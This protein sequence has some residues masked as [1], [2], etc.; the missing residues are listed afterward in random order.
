[1]AYI[2]LQFA[3][4]IVYVAGTINGIETV[5]EDRQ[6]KWYGYV[7]AVEDALYHLSL[8]IYDEAGNQTAY[9]DTLYYEL[10]WFV[11]DRTA[12][13]VEDRTSKGVL[14]ARDLNRIEKNTFTIGDLT[15]IAIS[16][17]YDWKN[18][19][20]PK[21]GDYERIRQ[22]TQKIRN[23]AHRRT[24]PEVPAR[25]LNHYQ[26]YNDI[27]QILKDAFDIYVGNKQN[28]SYAGEIYAGEEGVL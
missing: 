28:V 11:T 17:K 8:T 20:I 4:D 14:N 22:N 25:P 10:P 23:Y 1:M 26:K 18:G 24:T 15:S 16:A 27:E 19:D 5:F 3:S 7:E 2:A 12:A 13:D 9:T 21:E 6:G